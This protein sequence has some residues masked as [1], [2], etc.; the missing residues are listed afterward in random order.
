MEVAW[1]PSAPP[2]S[3]RGGRH[4]LWAATVLLIDA[5][6]LAAVAGGACTA[7]ASTGRHVELEHPGTLEADQVAV[8]I[9]AD[10]LVDD[11][12]PVAARVVGAR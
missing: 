9:V 11:H 7:R 10:D 8:Q 6:L 1:T 12:F 4:E 3:G 5:G 2:V